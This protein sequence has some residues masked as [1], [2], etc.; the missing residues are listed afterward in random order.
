MIQGT[1]GISIE[2]TTV[3]GV[4]DQGGGCGTV[5]VLV[6]AVFGIAKC[7]EGRSSGHGDTAAYS[8]GVDPDEVREDATADAVADL[9]ASSYQY[10]VGSYACTEDCSGHDA[11]WEWAA[12]ND[13]TDASDCYGQSTSFEEGCVAFADEVQSRADAAAE[14]AEAEVF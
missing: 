11:G 3:S 9:G 1:A 10:E 4:S 13:V 12:Q 6:L 8:A 5:I 2:T 7:V 14:E